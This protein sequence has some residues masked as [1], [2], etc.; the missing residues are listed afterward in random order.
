MALELQIS[1]QK[2]NEALNQIERSIESLR[3]SLERLSSAG[4]AFNNISASLAGLHIDPTVGKNVNDLSSALGRMSGVT[5]IGNIAQGLSQLSRINFQQ[6]AQGITTFNQQLAAMRV[7]PALAQMATAFHQIGQAA[8]QAGNQVR[9]FGAH[10][11]TGQQNMFGFNGSLS[12]ANNLLLAFGISLGAAGF[13]RFVQSSYEATSALQSF[14]AQMANL[15]GGND[16][17]A[18]TQFATDQF[19]FLRRVAR[20]TGQDIQ[21]LLPAYSRY[22]QATVRSGVSASES[23]SN[24]YKLSTAFRVLGLSTDQTNGAF[25]AFEQ[26][27][28]K[29][30]V[31]AEELRG[32]L[33]DRGVPALNAMATA[34]GVNTQELDRMMKAGQLGARDIQKM[35]DALYQMTAPGLAAAMQT[36]SARMAVFKNAVSEAQLVFGDGFF[37]GA[38]EGISSL[39][40]ALSSG[41]VLQAIE[42][43]GIGLG[44]VASGFLNFISVALQVGAALVNIFTPIVTFVTDAVNWVSNLVLGFSILSS[45]T[46]SLGQI[47]GFAAGALAFFLTIGAGIGSMV[48]TFRALAVTAAML[49]LAFSPLRIAIVGVVVALAGLVY[50]WSKY[51]GNAGLA[52]SATSTMSGVLSTLTGTSLEAG[53]ALANTATEY[54]DASSTTDTHTRSLQRNND[55]TRGSLSE[56]ARIQAA[57]RA[58]TAERARVDRATRD[59]TRSTQEGSSATNSHEAALRAL[60]AAMGGAV[61]GGNNLNQTM[62]SNVGS[63]NAANGAARE[64]GRTLEWVTSTGDRVP[65]LSGGSTQTYGGIRRPPRDT[66]SSSSDSSSNTPSTNP[67]LGDKTAGGVTNSPAYDPFDAWQTSS[68]NSWSDYSRID[69]N[70]YD[71][72]SSTPDVGKVSDYVSNDSYEDYGQFYRGGYVGG[73]R[74][75][76]RVPSSIFIGAPHYADGGYV[77]GPGEVPIIAH[78]GEAVVPL[79]DGRSI[80][81]MFMGGPG[82]DAESPNAAGSI[83][84]ID[85]VRALGVVFKNES[86]RWIRALEQQTIVLDVIA[87]KMSS[88]G[89]ST[90]GTTGGTT[91]TPP[92]TTADVAKTVSKKGWQGYGSG[93]GGGTFAADNRFE[94]ADDGTVRVRSQ[95]AMSVGGGGGGKDVPKFAAGTP[96]TSSTGNGAFMA[97]LHPDEAVIPLPDGRRVPV[98]LRMPADYD[99]PLRKATFRPNTQTTSNSNATAGGGRIQVNMYINTPDVGSFRSS[100]DQILKDLATKLERATSRIGTGAS[101]DDPTVRRK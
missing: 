83:S 62:N 92:V 28:T 68:N 12:S 76:R 41:G 74:D 23:A 91:T 88:S 25:R 81:V 34:L 101:V 21:T 16:V 35:T 1:G 85:Q 90:G 10:A 36:L 57:F 48:L 3:V 11:Q 31:Q 82:Y 59:L 37:R 96:N 14:K 30:R 13:A 70:A 66:L 80:P 40:A 63:F 84:L 61:G 17:A 87:A 55:A 64:Y 33:G 8:T 77:P 93:G 97:M 71:F 49:S 20:E 15:Y 98:D 51:T 32:Q 73:A 44:Q 78:Q 29:G 22:A 60:Q 4:N 42:T 2:A 45:E 47:L 50:I 69:N 39:T 24:F 26:M 67:D 86:D 27:V 7:P 72:P 89:T 99:S 75:S 79:P 6:L 95:N 18:Q 46:A 100:E 5:N 53:S 52:A 65:V 9:Q 54:Q 56:Q 38:T 43:L 94:I 19:N 58:E